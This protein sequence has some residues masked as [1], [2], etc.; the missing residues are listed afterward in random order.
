VELNLVDHPS[1]SSADISY[2]C[3]KL[4]SVHLSVCQC[5]RSPC[6]YCYGP[7]RCSSPARYSLRDFKVC[8]ELRRNKISINYAYNCILL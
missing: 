4:C 1:P 7:W 8:F 5:G 6:C 3:M 2:W